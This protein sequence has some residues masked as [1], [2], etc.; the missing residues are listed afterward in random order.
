MS[1]EA[2]ARREQGGGSARRGHEASP[3][4]PA[5]SQLHGSPGRAAAPGSG[6]P[7]AAAQADEAACLLALTS[8]LG[9][10][11]GQIAKAARP[12][13]SDGRTPDAA[14]V[15]RLIRARRERAAT[16]GAD[17]FS[18]PAW[19]MM[20]DLLA[21]R[22]ERR[23]VETSSLCIAAGVP[24]TT[25]LRLVRLMTERGLFV[26]SANPRDGRGVLVALSDDAAE[27]LLAHLAGIGAVA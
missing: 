18:D 19:D 8:E 24:S 5:F 22:L 10:L 12:L 7:A 17:L 26:R 27:R 13:A 23:V 21:A 1:G 3:P 20:L 9:R 16:F 4:R 14:F 25:A 2:A 6:G 11:A 15:R